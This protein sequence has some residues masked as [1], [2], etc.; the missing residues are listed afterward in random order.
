MGANKRAELMNNCM[1]VHVFRNVTLRWP[2]A[3][4]LGQ[5]ESMST[6]RPRISDHSSK[7][8]APHVETFEKSDRTLN[9]Y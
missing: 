1:Q 9:K 4:D 8:R 2:P 6:A 7:M 5:K 3:R